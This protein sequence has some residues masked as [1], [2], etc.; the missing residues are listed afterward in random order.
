MPFHTFLLQTSKK[1]P[2][3]HAYKKEIKKT[4]KSDASLSLFFKNTVK[5]AHCT[6]YFIFCL[7][8]YFWLCLKNP[9][10]SQ[11]NNYCNDTINTQ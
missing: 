6:F 1:N 8:K 9:A 11:L 2:E 4:V 5:M 3:V 10:S 7:Q